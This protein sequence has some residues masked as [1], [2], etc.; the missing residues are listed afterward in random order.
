M[1]FQLPGLVIYDTII[2]EH[3]VF[4]EKGRLYP[5]VEKRITVLNVKIDAVTMEQAVAKVENFIANPGRCHLVATANAEMVMMATNDPELHAIL[6]KADLVVADGAGVVWAARHQGNSVPER[7]A[8]YD[9]AQKLLDRSAQTGHKVYFFGG[10]PGVAE[11]AK[12]KAEEWYPGVNVVGVRNGFFSPED[13][14]K[15]LEDIKNCKPDILLV[16]LGVPKQEKWLSKHFAELHVPVA[17]GVGGTFDVMAGIMKRAP[18][19]MQ[20]ANLEWLF[21]LLMQPQR[22]L[23]M[24][25]LPK[26]VLRVLFDK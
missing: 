22:L 24:L 10:A 5:T 6:L 15:I 23:R 8:G 3:A 17:I 20:K 7:V 9:L 25:A 4:N 13:E 1:V 2:Q 11:Q 16:A 18:V 12:K 19:W 14:N 26:F 21:R